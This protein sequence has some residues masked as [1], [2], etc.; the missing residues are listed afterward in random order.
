MGLGG[1]LAPSVN[2]NR[3]EGRGW[4][5]SML[6][7]LPRGA[8]PRQKPSAANSAHRS[9]FQNGFSTSYVHTEG[10]KTTRTMRGMHSRG[11]RNEGRDG[12]V[13]PTVAINGVRGAPWRAR[14]EVPERERSVSEC[15]GVGEGASP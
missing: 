9:S 8:Q 11:S 10:T 1:E 14:D 12:K 13:P 5:R 6:Q 3:R 15:G 2:R 4:Y 7:Y